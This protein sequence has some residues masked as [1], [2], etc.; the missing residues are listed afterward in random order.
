MPSTLKEGTDLADAAV[1][2]RTAIIRQGGVPAPHGGYGSGPGERGLA[3][4]CHHTLKQGNVMWASGVSSYNWYYSDSV[5]TYVVRSPTPQQAEAYALLETAFARLE[6]V[7]HPG[8]NSSGVA[9]SAIQTVRDGGGDA[10]GL[11]MNIHTMGVEM[12]ELQHQPS[13]EGFPLEPNVCFCV[14]LLYKPGRDVFAIEHNYVVRQD[15][16]WEQLDTLPHNLIQVS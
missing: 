15:G 16:S 13:E 5:R 6:T 8:I 14:F 2:Y 4:R 1:T 3:S 9:K 12:V 10:D 11:E 7:Q